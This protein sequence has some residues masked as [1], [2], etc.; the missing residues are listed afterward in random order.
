M[1]SAAVLSE[2]QMTIP[3][4]KP[5]AAADLAVARRVLK[6]ETEALVALAASLDESFV[7]AVDLLMGVKGRIIVSGIGKSGHVGRKIAATF[8]S[9]GAPAQFVHPAE[10]SHGDL[11]M[12]TSE[13]V[14][15]VISN[16]GETKEL[17]DLLNHAARWRIPVIAISSRSQST[18]ARA[19]QAAL[20]LPQAGE[21]C[22]MGLAPTT[23][24]TMTIA[25]GDALAVAL[26]ERRAFN[27][28][29]FRMLHPGGTLGAALLR[30]DDLMRVGEALPLIRVDAPMAKAVEEITAKALGLVGVTDAR[31]SLVGVITDGD[32]RRNIVGLLDKPLS[33]VMSKTPVFVRRG[34]MAGEAVALMNGRKVT[35]LFVLEPEAVEGSGRGRPLGLLHIHDCLR[36]GVK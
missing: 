25:L 33:E 26:M 36:A 11:G 34:A 21:A 5:Q 3:P 7:K 9:T 35:A 30:V 29:R 16:S 23:S 12:I 10:A 27:P 4:Q 20:I 17:S 6:T 15:L 32:L 31:G 1:A 14:A 24:T 22:A 19:A 8:A 2:A 13:D 28:E 18:A